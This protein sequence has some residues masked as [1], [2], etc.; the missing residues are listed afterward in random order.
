MIKFFGKGKEPEEVKRT[1]K[2]HVPSDRVKDLS[3]KG[4]S[5]PEII[6]VLRKE[7]FSAGEIDRAL[8]QALKIGVTGAG[9]TESLP[10]LKELQTPM[11][12]GEPDEPFQ[13]QMPET[14]MQY[15]S[16]G[17]YGAEEL[18]ESIVEERMGGLDE[19]LVEFKAKYAALERGLSDL[20]HQLSIITKGRSEA[21]QTIVA[22][23]EALKE[24]MDDMN[25]RLSSLEKAFKE[26]LP[27]LI[28]S[29]RSLTELIQR[30]KKEA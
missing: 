22:K 15:Q 5:E 29:V 21:E 23:T 26:A 9:E 24:S 13:P 1:G 6:D 4:F 14:S 12:L 7:G 25:G 18:I 8:T 3:A 30:L 10:T 19:R 16:T 2:G 11:T 27:A 20:H 28:E 17:E